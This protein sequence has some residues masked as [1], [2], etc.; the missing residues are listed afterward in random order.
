MKKVLKIALPLVLIVGC[1][2]AIAICYIQSLNE[3]KPSGLCSL[4]LS[5]ASIN[6]KVGDEFNI[7]DACGVEYQASESQKPYYKSDDSSLLKVDTTTGD[8]QCLAKGDVKVFVYLKVS[9][10]EILKKEIIVSISEDIIYPTS[11][12]IEKTSIT[13]LCSGT[14]NNK[15]TMTENANSNVVVSSKNGLVTYDYKTGVVSSGGVEGEDVIT[16]VV[17]KSETETFSL[18]FQITVI[19]KNERTFSRTIS[20]EQSTKITYGD[21]LIP[22]GDSQMSAPALSNNNV[23][24]EDSDYGYVRVKGLS[25]G[26]CV[27][28]FDDGINFIEITIIV[29]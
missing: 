20:K 10:D 28:K 3:D 29:N 16:I 12:S 21:E 14:T 22:N 2:V 8:A 27:I 26:E 11:V 24:I 17:D 25:A 6:K 18:Q 7:V 23:E 9:A 13:M 4:S 5:C 19:K 1:L 15:L